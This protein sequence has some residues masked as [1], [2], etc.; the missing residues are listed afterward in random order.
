MFIGLDTETHLI[1]N[2]RRVPPLVCMSL[3]SRS[4][5][6]DRLMRKVPGDKLNLGEI[7]GVRCNWLLDKQAAIAAYPLLLEHNLVIQ[8]ASFDLLVMAEATGLIEETFLAVDENRVWDTIH[9][10]KLIANTYAELTMRWDPF[11]KRIAPAR[12]G[13]DTLVMRYLGHDIRA[14][15]TGGG[16]W[17]L[18]YADLEGIPLAQWPADAISYAMEDATYALQVFERQEVEHPPQCEGYSTRDTEDP[19]RF[20]GEWQ[21]VQA[22]LALTLQAIYGLR[23]DPGLVEKTLAR[24]HKLAAK[25]NAVGLRAGFLKQAKDGKVSRD[26]VRLQQAVAEGYGFEGVL[27]TPMITKK[28]GEPNARVR[29][30]NGPDAP[31]DFTPEDVRQLYPGIV[32][33]PSKMYPMGQVRD[34]TEV[35]RDAPVQ[36]R[37]LKRYSQSKQALNFISKWDKPE[38][39]IL[40]EGMTQPITYIID[41][42]KSTGRTGARKPAVQ[43]PPKTL[44]FRECFIPRRGYL[45]A[46]ADYG[47]IEMRCWA[48]VLERWDLGSTLADALR[49]GKD[50]HVM[51]GVNIL[52]AEGTHGL[53]GYETFIEALSGV[54]GPDLRKL[55]KDARQLAK[56]ANFGLMGGLGAP[57]LVEYAWKTYEMSITVDEAIR[58]KQLWLQTWPEARLYFANIN[59]K[60]RF[61]STFTAQLPVTGMLRGGLGFTDGCNTYFQA[62]AAVGFKAAA[63]DLACEMYV[64]CGT[65]LFGSRAVLPLHDEFV[66]EVPEDRAPEAAERLATVMRETMERHVPDIPIEVEPVL[67]ERWYKQ[68]ETVRDSSGRLQVWRPE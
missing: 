36:G 61:T 19:R 37:A 38:R 28:K 13:L 57:R 52:N 60:L 39:P 7:M 2:V 20:A 17:R 41:S 56:V 26:M 43:Q 46:G 35:L 25:G 32:S 47:Q 63:W 1:N 48:E 22:N 23:T 40:R 33:A 6:L 59:S 68:A 4:R 62:Y 58:L 64:D 12:F 66:I 30:V 44:G 16:S 45:Y 53:W 49:G 27:G 10:E 24:W 14:E 11:D 54:N 42:L 34:A 21:E 55:A 9:R 3:S 31:F 15:K 65:A 51:M 8:N 18:R 67:M 50:P 5:G 29:T